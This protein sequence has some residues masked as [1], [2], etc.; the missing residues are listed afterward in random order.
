MELWKRDQDFWYDRSNNIDQKTNQSI[1]NTKKERLFVVVVGSAGRRFGIVVDS[2][3][4]Q[5][6]MVI[7]SLGR[8]LSDLPCIAGG[9][10][11]GNGEVVL[12]LDIAE[13]DDNFRTK[14]RQV[15]A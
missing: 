8:I 12:V 1:G 14:L 9:S 15:A 3:L 13:L 2:L 4:N 5:Q 11:L 7:K 10:I 6:E